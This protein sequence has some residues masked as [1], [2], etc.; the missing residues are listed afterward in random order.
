MEKRKNEVLAVEF[1]KNRREPNLLKAGSRWP[2]E[3]HS[4][5]STR[6]QPVLANSRKN[7]PLFLDGVV[8]PDE[9]RQKDERSCDTCN[10][11]KCEIKIQ[12]EYPLK[13]GMDAKENLKRSTALDG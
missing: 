6:K 7:K 4:S 2:G 1:A 11:A 5:P 13:K 12:C 3:H 10:C 8:E 9:K